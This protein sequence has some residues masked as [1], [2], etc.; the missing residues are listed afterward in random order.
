MAVWSA[1]CPPP[2]AALRIAILNPQCR[3]LAELRHSRY[4]KTRF[5]VVRS[6]NAVIK[7]QPDT[8]IPYLFSSDDADSGWCH[9]SLLV[10]R[11]GVMD[12]C[13][14][15]KSIHM[16]RNFRPLSAVWLCSF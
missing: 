5:E 2:R 8:E 9:L 14:T 13:K 3:K 1:S 12:L 7:L 16:A 4:S 6:F 11:S 10:M 15:K